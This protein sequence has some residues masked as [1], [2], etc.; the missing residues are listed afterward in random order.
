VD[1][2]LP[3]ELCRAFAP[4][5]AQ[6]ARK[7]LQHIFD[8]LP[9]SPVRGFAKQNGIR[10]HSDECVAVGVFDEQDFLLNRDAFGFF[11]SSG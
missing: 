6:P 5:G 3:T 11:H 7:Q 8:E 9:E 1:K 10:A 2:I 4:V